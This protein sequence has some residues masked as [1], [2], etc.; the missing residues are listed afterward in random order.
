MGTVSFR[1]SFSFSVKHAACH[2]LQTNE[3]IVGIGADSQE[4]R[5]N[6]LLQNLILPE[7]ISE[8]RRQLE[9]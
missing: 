6:S 3:E 1:V 7:Y 4:L 8:E 9:P 5:V 2:G